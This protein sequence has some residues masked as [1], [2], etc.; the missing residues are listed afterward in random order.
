VKRFA[1]SAGEGGRH[2]SWQVLATDV[3]WGGW[4]NSRDDK[5]NPRMFPEIKLRENKQDRVRNQESPEAWEK[6]KDG[7]HTSALVS[8]PLIARVCLQV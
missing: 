5:D 8:N 4:R 7:V 6:P 3:P 2:G 1:P